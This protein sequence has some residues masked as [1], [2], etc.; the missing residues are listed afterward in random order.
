MNINTKNK[1]ILVTGAGG[2]IGS[3]HMLSN[4][5]NLSPKLSYNFD[6]NEYS[7]YIPIENKIKENINLDDINVYPIL[8]NVD[9]KKLD[10]L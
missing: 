2:S 1:N 3:G 6:N 10:Q 8:G 4:T 9:N 7:L 5:Q